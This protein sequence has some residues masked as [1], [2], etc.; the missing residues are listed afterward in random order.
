MAEYVSIEEVKLAYKKFKSY[1]YYDNTGL[2]MRKQIADFEANDFEQ[3]LESIYNHLKGISNIEIFF[4]GSNDYFDSLIEKICFW[5]VPKKIPSSSKNSGQLLTNYRLEKSV[6]IKDFIFHVNAPIELHIIAVLWIMKE[7]QHLIS[8]L[9]FSY[10]YV[11]DKNDTNNDIVNGL[12][13]F[14]P[15]YNEYQKW[16]DRAI[17]SAKN[18]LKENQNVGI[19]SL[20]IKNFYHSVNL[21]FDKVEDSLIDKN[22]ETLLTKL[23]KK[24]YLHYTNIISK[25]IGNINKLDKS[26][27]PIGFLS[28]GILANWYLIDFDN[29]VNEKLS[30]VYYGRYV[31]DILLSIPLGNLTKY[32]SSEALIKDLFEDNGIL[33]KIE[34]KKDHDN[35]LI[36]KLEA[37]D[38]LEIQDEKIIIMLF[39]KNEPTSLLDKFKNEI[40]KSSSEYR[41][42]PNEDLVNENFEQSSSKLIY[43]GSKNKLRSIKEF[44][45]DRFGISSFLAKKIFL[46]LQSNS[47][48]NESSQQ[49]L[50]FFKDTR[51]LEYSFLWEKIATF[52]ILSND[53][54]SLKIFIRNVNRSIA[55]ISN[56]NEQEII[57]NYYE[58]LSIVISLAISIKIEFFR[59]IDFFTDYIELSERFRNARLIRKNYSKVPLAE[60]INHKDKRYKKFID[61]TDQYISIKPESLLEYKFYPRYIHYHE[62]LLAS[63]INKILNGSIERSNI[64]DI[65]KNAQE[66]FNQVS[67]SSDSTLDYISKII[68]DEDQV[69][70]VTL[71]EN[72]CKDNLK[73]GVANFTIKSEIFTAKYIRKPEVNPN[74]KK[75]LI[76]ILN[77]SINEKVDLIVLPEC[78][79]PFSWLYWIVNFAHNKQIGLVFGL[80]H[81][82]GSKNKVYNLMVTLLPVKLKKYNSLFI[83]I[84]VKKHYSPEEKRILKGYGYSIPK[85]INNQVIYNWNCIHFTAF[86]CYELADINDRARFKSKVDLVV[87]CEYNKDTKY[88]SNIVESS[89]RDLHCYFVQS[90]SAHYGD[91]RIYQPTSSNYSDILKI[92]GGENSTLLVGTINIKK[93]REFQ[94]TEYELQRS[95]KSFKPTPPD[96]NRGILKDRINESDSVKKDI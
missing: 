23:L 71:Q 36:Y 89:A 24:I 47:K 48:D 58:Q 35:S 56:S 92:K 85:N 5:K 11:L 82:I 79:I 40:R 68:N 51:C 22:V 43:D 81:V 54:I 76:K 26:I 14:K 63:Y 3:R 2:F 73:V 53:I 96:Y 52:F 37:Y 9:D 46:V 50:D 38:S 12:R 80:E 87:A 42:L 91:N 30:P 64:E 34:T 7:G 90:N 75:E 33:I 59:N 4:N 95:D 20:D 8:N 94:N 66:I 15:Y 83:D 86:N 78:S 45:D 65:N 28:S 18:V 41:F 67:N 25:N 61:I 19:I 88:F 1:V 32:D 6:E 10:G 55:L 27:L 93:L 77:Q 70:Q 72:I 13:L 29:Q 62:I 69:Y 49:I 84:R 39:D 31:D 60:L 57:D 21:D 44:Q 17:E 16:R 74:R